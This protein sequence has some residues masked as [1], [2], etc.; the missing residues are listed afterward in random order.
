[1]SL[2]RLPAVDR[3]LPRIA[4][5][6]DARAIRQF[7]SCAAL[8]PSSDQSASTWANTKWRH[9]S[10]RI[11]NSKTCRSLLHRAG[12]LGLILSRDMREAYEDVLTIL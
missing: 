7:S 9:T 8:I 12:R 10:K 3:A 1:M 11:A 2:D 4:D 5:G 6:V